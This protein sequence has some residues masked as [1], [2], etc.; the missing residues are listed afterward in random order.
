[1]GFM[2]F[3]RLRDIFAFFFGE[4]SSQGGSKPASTKVIAAPIDQMLGLIHESDF[5]K[6][7]YKRRISARPERPGQFSFPEGAR[8]QRLLSAHGPAVARR[9]TG[10][11]VADVGVDG[12]SELETLIGY[13]VISD[14][15]NC[16]KFMLKLS[17][18]YGRFNFKFRRGGKSLHHIMNTRGLFSIMRTA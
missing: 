8:R 15:H 13:F 5:N 1:M 18:F 4:R 10:P 9:G 11:A 12:F 7:Y 14:G 16:L 2:G 6:T 3:L 17:E